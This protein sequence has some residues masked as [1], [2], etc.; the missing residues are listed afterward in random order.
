VLRIADGLIA[1]VDVF[2]QPGLVER[3]AVTGPA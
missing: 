3:F 1:E 2:M